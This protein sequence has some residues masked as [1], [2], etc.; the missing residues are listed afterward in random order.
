M[1]YPQCSMDKK[2]S[3]MLNLKSG[4]TINYKILYFFL[5]IPL[6][7]SSSFLFSTQAQIKPKKGQ[8]NKIK[9]SV[10]QA[11]RSAEVGK[12]ES[13]TA[14]T[15]PVV[16]IHMS[17][18]PNGK[19]IAW[20][21]N[22]GGKK[23]H[24]TVVQIWDPKST[25]PQ[26]KETIELPV[27]FGNLFC[28]GHSF[29]PDG[30]LLIT[31]GQEE[32]TEVSPVGSRKAALYDYATGNWQQLPDMNDR[33]WYP[34]NLTLGNGNTVVW[35]GITRN[36]N[37]NKKPQILEEQS[38]GTF[39]WRTLN[40][41]NQET[42][43]LYYSWL[44]LLSSGKVLTTV[45]FQAKSYLLTVGGNYK[46]PRD[47]LYHYPI[48]PLDSDLS[49]KEPHDAGSL[50]VY[51][52]DKMLVVGG[53]DLPKPLVETIDMSEPN[54]IWKKAR[55]L[56]IG[57]RHLNSTLLPDGTILVTGGNKG[58]G[59]N[60]TCPQNAVT[61]AELWNPNDPVGDEKNGD[62]Y[63]KPLASSS[64]TRI[65]HSTAVLLPDGR[66]LSGG[67]TQ[68]V[69]EGNEVYPVD[70]ENPLICYFPVED[71]FQMEIFSPPYLFNP[72]GSLAERPEIA[73]IPTKVNYGDTI[74]F[75]AGGAMGTGTSKVN[76][77]RLPSVTHSFNQNQGIVKLTPMIKG[78]NA[79]ITIPLNR[80]EC[81]P[82]HYMMFLINGSG[83]PSEAKIIQI[84]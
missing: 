4:N 10:P 25:F 23:R 83:V 51:D 8:E 48:S 84:L 57:R 59:F 58:N 2:G 16:P 72:D 54:P 65:Y 69:A 26:S 55:S 31:G 6:I 45:G 3:I 56:N 35:A 24:Q 71:N 27:S 50:V 14:F 9:D 21:A 64:Q 70:P 80:N 29:L 52:K 61:M 43:N 37:I 33:R 76:L 1:L 41:E 47:F 77:I 18:L 39:T 11:R 75:Y 20:G 60:N 44:N 22:L 36:G 19:V 62:V 17:I 28:S 67:T 63:W 46:Y 38:D 79:Q 34:T 5:L 13:V 15:D 68:S 66:I 73:N 81:P 40:I 78:N 30:R 32:T 12:W 74:G 42:G 49:L 7:L 53:A 82:G